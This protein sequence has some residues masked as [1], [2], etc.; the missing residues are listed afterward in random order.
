MLPHAYANNMQI[1][2]QDAF[3]IFFSSTLEEM[4]AVVDGFIILVETIVA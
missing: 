3:Y 2:T 4:P 1:R